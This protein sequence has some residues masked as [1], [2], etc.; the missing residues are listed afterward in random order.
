VFTPEAGFLYD[1][2]A[3]QTNGRCV[4]F[5]V[6]KTT[7]F[8]TKEAVNMISSEYVGVAKFS[9]PPPPQPLS[10][11][12]RELLLEQDKLGYLVRANR[13][14]AENLFRVSEDGDR[15]LLSIAD[16]EQARD[17]SYLQYTRRIY[18][19][20]IQEDALAQVE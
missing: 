19:Y 10:G 14:W 8:G 18:W 3:I 17:A 15:L 4:F 2:P 5:V 6:R 20:S 16:E 7:G 13:A 12:K 1:H 9:L 11:L